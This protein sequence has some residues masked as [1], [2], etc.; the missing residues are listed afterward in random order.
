MPVDAGRTTFDLRKPK[1]ALRVCVDFGV[2]FGV[3][4]PSNASHGSSKIYNIFFECF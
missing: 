4:L 1:R 3:V 2:V